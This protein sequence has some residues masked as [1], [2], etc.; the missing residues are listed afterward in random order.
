MVETGIIDETLNVLKRGFQRNAPGF[1]GIGYRE[2]FDFIDGHIS[3]EKLV[4]RIYTQTLKYIKRQ[5]TW[6][7][8]EKEINWIDAQNKT[9]MECA[10]EIVALWKE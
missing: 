6:F 9:Y 10:S 1:E 4:E 5:I 2:V 8:K 3:K 7:K